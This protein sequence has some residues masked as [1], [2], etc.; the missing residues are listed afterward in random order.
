MDTNRLRLINKLTLSIAAYLI[1][2]FLFIV[3]K[4]SKFDI[5]DGLLLTAY[6]F[7]IPV[8]T[9]FG[10]STSSGILDLIINGYSLILAVAIS[11]CV[12]KSIRY[13]NPEKDAKYEIIGILLLIP[14]FIGA[15]LLL[16]LAHLH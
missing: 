14:W 10:A 5:V 12:Y 8:L 3:L 9:L 15:Y 2:S 13:A 16:L 1:L 4:S 11:I 6:P 7:S